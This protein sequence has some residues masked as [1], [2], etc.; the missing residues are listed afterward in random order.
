MRTVTIA[1]PRDV[2]TLRPS[3]TGRAILAVYD[4]TFPAGE[5]VITSTFADG[6]TRRQVIPCMG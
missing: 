1:T 4:G 3:S 2:R 6:S 5:T